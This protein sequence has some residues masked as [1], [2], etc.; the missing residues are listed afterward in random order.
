MKKI[1]IAALGILGALGMSTNQ[2]PGERLVRSQNHRNAETPQNQRNNSPQQ[3]QQ[4]SSRES[5]EIK[6]RYHTSQAG[7]GGS[8]Y[9]PGIPPKIYGMNYVK[10]GTHKRTNI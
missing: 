1:G 5:I 9:N 2:A 3:N 6:D 7:N 8:W 10:R 4:L